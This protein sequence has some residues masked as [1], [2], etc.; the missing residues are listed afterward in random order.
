M[1]SLFNLTPA[2][3]K[4]AQRLK[5]GSGMSASDAIYEVLTIR[6]KFI[7]G[8]IQGVACLIVAAIGIFLAYRWFSQFQ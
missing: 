2:Q 6:Q 3:Q 5:I 8:F 1:I 4:R 7:Y